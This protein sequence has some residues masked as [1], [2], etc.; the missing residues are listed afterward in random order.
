M[1]RIA[2]FLYGV[3]SYLIF[4]VTIFYLVGFV[5]DFFVPKTLDSGREGSLIQALIIDLGLFCLFGLQHSVMARPGFKARWT[6]I[7]PQ[8]LERS[9]YVLMASFTLL[10]LFWQWHSLGGFIWQVQNSVVSSLL[11]TISGIGWLIV[12]ASTFL[13]DHFDL[14]GLRQVYLYLRCQEYQH[15]QFKTVGL[16]KYVRH[17]LMLGFI[18]ALWATPQMT[19]THLFFALGMTIY[20]L[21]GIR[22]EERDMISIYGD[23]YQHYRQQ[24]SMLIPLPKT[25]EII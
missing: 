7:I 14:F 23:L 3:I 9:T 17:P 4:A 15:L 18:I 20:M 12:F 11:Y 6:K 5:G 16:Y 10:L 8:P 21:I 25:R 19:V 2:F 1:K 22:L 24:V 13:I